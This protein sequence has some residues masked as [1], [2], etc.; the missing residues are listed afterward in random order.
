MG[1]K[2]S[3]E[4]DLLRFMGKS[5]NQVQTMLKECIY[6]K[7]VICCENIKW[8]YISGVFQMEDVE[9]YPPVNFETDFSLKTKW[10]NLGEVR[11]THAQLYKKSWICHCYTLLIIKW[12]SEF[13]TFTHVKF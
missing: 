11:I 2:R 9:M 8:V 10:K 1:K 4:F 5:A 6:V 12:I 13:K 7:G 3:T